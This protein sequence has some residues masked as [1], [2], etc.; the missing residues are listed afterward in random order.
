M[1]TSK[2]QKAA[3]TYLES[4]KSK[5]P[6]TKGKILEQSGFS[7]TSS[8]LPQRVF[9]SQGFQEVLS[10]V[11]DQSILRKWEKWAVSEKDKR[12][13]LQAGK[14]IMTLKNRYPSDTVAAE[15]GDFKLLIKKNNNNENNQ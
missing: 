12:T 1:S 7:K 13:A 8:R 6:L 15:M 14:E 11:D 9:N 3:E 4:R 5:N 10:G 2:Q